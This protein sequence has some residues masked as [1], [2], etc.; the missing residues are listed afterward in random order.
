MGVSRDDSTCRFSIQL[1]TNVLLGLDITN[2]FVL[3]IQSIAVYSHLV[4]RQLLHVYVD[5][6]PVPKTFTI[7]YFAFVE[8]H[9]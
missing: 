3:L 2:N 9:H 1:F 6:G 8:A 4:L 5:R 7:N